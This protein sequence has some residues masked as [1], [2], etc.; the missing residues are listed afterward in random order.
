MGTVVS[1]RL[2]DDLLQA[3]DA[4]AAERQATRS[5]LLRALVED[6]VDVGDLPDVPPPSQDD[7]LGRLRDLTT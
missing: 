5:A 1:T 4:A 3:I 7:E 2:P 6:A